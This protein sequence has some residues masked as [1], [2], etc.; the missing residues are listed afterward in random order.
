[1]TTRLED[2]TLADIP[3]PIFPPTVAKIY[4]K[5]IK[6]DEYFEFNKLKFILDNWTSDEVQNI[7]TERTFSE[8]DLN[9]IFQH[10][11][12]TLKRAKPEVD[13]T[14]RLGL[15]KVQ[16]KQ[17]REG[18]FQVYWGKEKGDYMPACA[19][20]MIREI[21]NI[22]Y[23]DIVY[24]LDIAAC[25]PTLM[26]QYFQKNGYNL[27]P[28]EDYLINRADYLE[29]MT[30]LMNCNTDEAK[31]HF[32][33]MVYGSKEC[34]RAIFD[35]RNCPEEAMPMIIKI[36][37]F[38]DAVK[39]VHK[40]LAES[41]PERFNIVV[42]DLESQKGKDPH[43][44]FSSLFCQ[45][46][47]NEILQAM[48]AFAK[49]KKVHVNSLIF[50][51]FNVRRRD[52]KEE[53]LPL[54]LTEMMAHVFAETG[55]AV[56]IIRKEMKPSLDITKE[57]ITAS[58]KV[59]A[60]VIK[61]KSDFLDILEGDDG[62]AR[63]YTKLFGRENLHI[64]EK[65]GSG[66]LW[67]EKR[68]LWEFMPAVN[69][70]PTIATVLLPVIDTLLCESLEE[71]IERE[72]RIMRIDLQTDKETRGVFQRIIPLCWD[73]QFFG[74]LNS[75]A[76]VVP[77]KG[78][79]IINLKTLDVYDRTR[80][81]LFDYEC[82]VNYSPDAE[83]DVPSKFLM[84]IA[85]NDADLADYLRRFFGYCLTGEVTD[86]SI[87]I[88][89]GK[90]RNGKSTM[91]DILKAFKG[92]VATIDKSA[93]LSGKKGKGAASPELMVFK[94]ARIAICNELDENEKLDSTNTKTITGRDTI[95]ARTLFSSTYIDF[96]SPSKIV[97]PTNNK[98]EF[99]VSDP[100]IID[101]L[102]YIPFLNTYENS[103]ANIAY[104]RSL[105]EPINLDAFFTLF[106][107]A[108]KEWYDGNV[109][110]PCEVM[111][112]EK[113][114]SINDLDDVQRWIEECCEVSS[115]VNISGSTAYDSFTRWFDGHLSATSFGTKL[116]AK[117]EKKKVHGVMVY[118]GLRLATL[119]V[120]SSS[121]G[122]CGA[123]L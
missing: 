39:M 9:T 59:T 85:N 29:G 88:F 12:M 47:E 93:L 98:P 102:K 121:G 116:T 22:L 76:H 4:D 120:M 118:S 86:R 75:C 80:L 6:F 55:Y 110:V 50:D 5:P 83:V 90:G 13:G 56:K 95:T 37:H 25:H 81:D 113:S 57:M 49:K 3:S 87:H 114:R 108:A 52:L 112:S 42:E 7:F 46:I 20:T 70:R 27:L 41:N 54:F 79:K 89:W 15:I 51:G 19:Q 30:R 92:K 32:T 100:A 58:R 82:V 96:N 69:L 123:P 65:D 35:S 66:F 23:N 38:F 73:M 117:F 115:E 10:L 48:V 103:P 45:N 84:S 97:L 64:T 18:R 36:Q 61:V 1:M 119:P 105:L 94:D 111:V 91:L 77:I 2:F 26:C 71:K 62:K 72:L 101:R 8:T 44:S 99:N 17:V 31:T 43:R 16:Y 34:E 104:G 33:A 63:L 24:D 40:I 14:T 68:R 106:A 28:L 21:R 78:G 107:K 60:S 109:L 122:T 11:K 74:F 67:S 53:D